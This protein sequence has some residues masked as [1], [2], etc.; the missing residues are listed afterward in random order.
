MK[1]R[2]TPG[3]NITG[4]ITIAALIR[5][6]SVTE[7]DALISLHTSGGVGSGYGLFIEGNNTLDF[8]N[9]V[10]DAYS[11]SGALINNEWQ[12]VAVTKGAGTVT[13]RFHVYRFSTNT[14]THKNAT[15]SLGNGASTSGGTIQ[16]GTWQGG[17]R[18]DGEFA[19][20]ALYSYALSDGDIES[21]AVSY[22]NWLTR[23]PAGMWVLNQV[24]PTHPLLDETAGGGDEIFENG[25]FTSV[26]ANQSPLSGDP[27]KTIFRGD[28]SNG[29]ASEWWEVQQWPNSGT[30]HFSVIGDNTNPDGEKY[31]GHFALGKGDIRSELR[32]GLRLYAGENVY[33]RFLARLS[34]QFPAEE[35]PGVWGE[36]IW[37]LHQKSNEGTPPIALHIIETNPGK[38]ALRD[39]EDKPWWVG[40]AIDYGQ[41]HEFIIR[42]NH[43]PNDETG[44]VELWMDGN[45]QTLANGQTRYYKKTMLDEFN[46]PKAGYY[47]SQYMVG[48]GAVDIAGYRISRGLE[49][50]THDFDFSL[51][52]GAGGSGTGQFVFS[53]GIAVDVSGNVWVADGGNHRVQKFNSKGEYLGQFGGYG[54][55]NGQFKTPV[56]IAITEGGDLWITDSGNS[57]VQKFNSKGEYLGKFG[58]YGLSNGQ[59][60]EPSGIDIAPNGNIWVS[61]HGYYR[62]EEFTSNGAFVRSVHGLG[63]GEAPGEFGAPSGV[64]VDQQG[65][66]WVVDSPNHRVQELSA[67][68]EY[69]SEF[70]DYGTGDG[71]FAEPTV[72]DV[73]PTGNL[74]VA[75]R[76][77]GRIQL[78][79]PEGEHLT[80]FG[81]G[82]FWEPAG[83]A[84][85][86]GGA[87]V[88]NSRNDRVELWLGP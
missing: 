1:V 24:D 35:G 53:R 23:E 9:G 20:T 51:K 33:I 84:A 65:H 83:I 62:V 52:F 57:R 48:N 69:L 79:S 64:A 39:S 5:P 43:S 80:T 73:T 34:E 6:H 17:W 42:V 25:L 21:L 72:I 60:V 31:Y 45:Q 19:A 38:F 3:T 40:P 4:A 16:L 81:G 66:V 44:F 61:D 58:T 11:S 15:S 63:W 67:A 88:A 47:R 41:W 59:F 8:W 76:E 26:I 49:D 32:T 29:D 55:G 36:V 70:G 74:L 77:T 7:G 37:Q 46:Y 71:K 86:V 54:T 68:G 10:K 82:N 87:Y 78:F 13:P 28:L 75:D 56:D 50:I 22:S 12:L 18:Y 27:E 14:W 30:A 85:S 2:T